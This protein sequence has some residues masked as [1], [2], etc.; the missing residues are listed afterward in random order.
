MSIELS[1]PQCKKSV[2]WNEDYPFR[3]FCSQRCQLIDLGDWA[4]EKFSIPVSAENN[5][6]EIWE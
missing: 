6:E 1:C 4:D 5:N 2:L 3:P